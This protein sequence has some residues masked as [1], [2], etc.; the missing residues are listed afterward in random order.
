MAGIYDMATAIRQPDARNLAQGLQMGQQ[1][2]DNRRQNQARNALAR[3]QQGDTSAMADLQM[4]DPDAA[5]KWGEMQRA[6]SDRKGLMGFLKPATGAT[7]VVGVNSLSAL[8][9][10]QPAQPASYDFDGAM[11]YAAGRG[12]IEKAAA[13]AQLR[14]KMKPQSSKYYGGD[15]QEVIGKDGQRRLIA[16]TEQG[17]VELPYQPVIKAE[18]PKAPQ[19]RSLKM[20]GREV[21]QEW[22]G[23]QWVTVADAPRE[24]PK[25]EPPRL[26]E[27]TNGYE[28]VYPGEIPTGK[29]KPASGGATTEDAKKAAGYA[30][31][32]DL[33]IELMD[34]IVADGAS[35]TGG[36]NEVFSRGL[37]VFG[38]GNFTRSPDNQRLEAARLDALD[39]ALTLNTG[40]AYTKEQL[41]GLAKS[42]FPQ[43]GDS[44]KT[45]EEKAARFKNVVDT[46]R[47]RAGQM[48]TDGT[49]SV[50]KEKPAPSGITK[51]TATAV[52]WLK[53]KKITNQEQFNTAVADLKK[54]GWN[55]EEINQALD[56][57]GL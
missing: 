37:D 36:A 29:P 24:M 54:Q 19:T 34:K 41:T 51:N 8:A 26:V 17:P 30:K 3:L 25:Q 52:L 33:S 21:T 1:L 48:G 10:G 15:A 23:S 32:M 9:N 16:M 11:N 56:K 14:D 6:E 4:A 47:I 27:T 35:A 46:A 53:S 38:L 42:Y 12:E 55:P 13:L 31:R 50:T 57:A 7:N 2:A 43:P 18:T 45:V 49:Q 5:M 20:G 22:N 40:A 39:A 44:K 28:W